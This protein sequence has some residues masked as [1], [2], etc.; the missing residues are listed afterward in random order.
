MVAEVSV[1]RCTI[2]HMTYG[3]PDTFR[4]LALEYL[5]ADVAEKWLSLLRPTVALEAATGTDV[6]VGQLGGLPRLPADVEWPTW[7]GRGALSH[8][9]SVDCAAL[10]TGALD[11]DLPTDGTL[12]FF[13][14]DGQVDDGPFVT[15]SDRESWAGARV[16]HVP[17]DSACA[18]REVPAGLR[19]YPRVPLTAQVKMTAAEPW[20]PRIKNAFRSDWPSGRMSDH[21]VYA[22]EFSEALWEHDDWSGH[23]I[24]GYADPAQDAV[25]AEVAKGVLGPEVPW[26]DPR[27]DQEAA[28]WVLLAQFDS[29]DAAD[30][31]WGD[32]GALY[33]LIRPKDLAERRFDRAGFTW[34][35]T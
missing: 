33:W 35:C 19:A 29:D 16:L 12:L 15:G 23:R 5:P 22:P 28:E 13:Y 31:M 8:I 4:D 11:I 34:Q 1:V 27:V 18:E 26:T 20:H 24:G 17:A 7:E 9:A 25:E 14:F 32:C 3:S 6:V 30:M 10:P 21:P 2:G